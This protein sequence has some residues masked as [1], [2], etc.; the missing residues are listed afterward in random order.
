MSKELKENSFDLAFGAGTGIAMV[1]V[2]ELV[3]NIDQALFPQAFEALRKHMD[4][5]QV[6]INQPHFESMIYL[7][8][9]PLATAIV[10]GISALVGYIVARTS[11]D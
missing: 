10:F 6:L 5:F 8:N 2:E 4:F 11:R 3:T 1:A 9:R 7:D